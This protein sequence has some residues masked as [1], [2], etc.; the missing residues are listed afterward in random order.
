MPPYYS[1][2]KVERANTVHETTES[3]RRIL[4]MGPLVEKELLADIPVD[5]IYGDRD[6]MEPA[7]GMEVVERMKAA[8]RKNVEGYV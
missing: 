6:W 4:P 5:F 3:L 1:V 7:H 2:V 8:G